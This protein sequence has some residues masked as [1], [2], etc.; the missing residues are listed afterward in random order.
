VSAPVI[1]GAGTGGFTFATVRPTAKLVMSWS[2]ANAKYR[3][4][5]RVAARRTNEMSPTWSMRARSIGTR[6]RPTLASLTP[7]PPRAGLFLAAR[8]WTL[9]A[10]A[11]CPFSPF[12]TASR[13]RRRQKS[14]LW[15]VG[16][17]RRASHAAGCTAAESRH[18]LHELR[19]WAIHGRG[20]VEGT[21]WAAPG[22]GATASPS[23]SY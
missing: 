19:A 14:L 3:W 21:A 12:V 15:C 22:R 6:D 18:C 8:F 4:A 5:S 10:T 17:E 16:T 13:V 20:R 11:G 2:D 9:A 1:C 23:R 7:A